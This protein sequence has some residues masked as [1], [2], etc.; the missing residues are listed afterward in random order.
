MSW[1]SIYVALQREAVFPCSGFD[2]EPFYS[3]KTAGHHVATPLT[4][5]GD[6]HEVDLI[7]IFLS[8]DY[9]PCKVIVILI[10]GEETKIK[11]MEIIKKRQK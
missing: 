2:T 8:G 9:F 3:P 6:N 11:R 5:D 1:T 10:Y 4:S 7:I